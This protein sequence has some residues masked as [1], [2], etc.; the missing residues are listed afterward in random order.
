MRLFHLVYMNS[1][2][3]TNNLLLV[4]HHNS[5]HS[6]HHYKYI[7][8]EVIQQSMLVRHLLE[9]SLSQ[10]NVMQRYMQDLQHSYLEVLSNMH[11]Q[12][13]FL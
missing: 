6:I 13:L 2:L 8:T 7:H 3:L 12:Q 10:Y 4:L 9:H 5:L 11:Q 1:F